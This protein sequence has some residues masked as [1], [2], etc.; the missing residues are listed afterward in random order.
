MRFL[1][2]V[3]LAGSAFTAQAQ[4]IAPQVQV[5]PM[6][7]TVAV[8]ATAQAERRADTA[9]VH[10]GYQLY[11]ATSRE[12]AEQASTV[13]KAIADAEAKTGVPA[14]ALESESQST[15]PVQDYSN[16]GRD[17]AEQARRKFQ[18]QQSWTVRVPA[19][20][21]SKVL[22]AAVAAG[23]NQSGAIDWSI[24]DED[25]LTAEAAGKA[26]KHAQ[27]VAGQM[28]AGLGAKLGPLV[29]ASNEAQQADPQPLNLRMAPAASSVKSEAQAVQLSLGPQIVRRSAT[30][31][32]VFA[33]Q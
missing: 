1:A 18:A 10:I 11:A 9:A 31:Y 28:A 23:A 17:P 26:L 21:S 14:D 27:A 4:Q 7:R 22:A 16:N 32:A 30:V 25:A 2:V 20:L 13:S 3:L 8:T 33:L 29:Y 15:G 6:N 5:G 12:V 24:A 19:A